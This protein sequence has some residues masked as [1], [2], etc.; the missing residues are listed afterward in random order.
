MDA[1]ACSAITALDLAENS[2]GAE[3]ARQLAPLATRTLEVLVLDRNC[4][5]TAAAALAGTA[6]ALSLRDASLEA[7]ACDWGELANG[8][9]EL[10][11]S[12]NDL[13]GSGEIAAVVVPG[14]RRLSERLLA[15]SGLT[16]CSVGL[17]NFTV[18]RNRRS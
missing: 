9:T 3:A 2:L 11:L 4:I 6:R 7:N 13:A 17:E 18:T 8:L 15:A 10:D 16:F 12:G 5:G 14:L 1:I